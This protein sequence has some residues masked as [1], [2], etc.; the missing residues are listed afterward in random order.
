MRCR[1]KIVCTLGPAVD[2][3]ER[4]KALMDAGMS[5]ARINCSHGDWDT[6]RQW[7]EWIREL[8][9]DLTPLGV[10]IDLQGPKFRI[11]VVSNG[12]IEL[13]AGQSVLLGDDEGCAIPIVQPEVCAALE[14]GC[15]VLLGDG[16]VEIKLTQEQGHL[17]QGKVVSG[18][19]VK[20]KQG[21][22]LVGKVF[23]SPCL[24]EQ[25][26]RDIQEAAKLAPEFIALS[27]VRQAQDIR[28]LKRVL[29]PLDPQVM[30]CAKV[31]TREAVKNLDEII[32]VSDLIMI[33]R[34]DMGLQM[35]I[36]EVPLVQKKIIRACS[37]AG[38]PVITATQMLESMVNSPRPTRAEA[39]DV[40]NA[41][42]DGTDALMLSGE[43]ASGLYPVECVKMMVK[44]AEK[45]E[46]NLDRTPIEQRLKDL[47]KKRELSMT[48]AVAHSAANL[49]KLLDADAVITTTTSGQTTRLVSKF[50]PKVPIFCATLSDRTHRQMSIVWGVESLFVPKP[51]TTDEN[52]IGSMDAFCRQK[53]LK[54]GD[55]VVVTSGWP[56]GIPGNTNLITTQRV[57]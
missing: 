1:T 28:D 51:Q 41:I 11:G 46:P 29:E 45:M 22:T 26:L 10:L 52:I 7:I 49:C 40:A 21:I 32:K 4:I 50:R 35:D 17:Y 14:V 19:I 24:T 30:V 6:R 15:R 23:D 16:N 27:Y 13:A 5:V 43:T 8:S 33:A 55:T 39:T 57:K 2:S 12:S 9:S 34:G 18:G 3:K 42:L 47:T 44:I 37:D 36:E 53:R 25:D 48:E 31:E 56:V 54:S 38:K 20:S